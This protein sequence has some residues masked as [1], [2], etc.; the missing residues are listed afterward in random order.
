MNL[1]GK[2]KVE[3]VPFDAHEQSQK[4]A[5]RE[6]DANQNPQEFPKA[7]DHVED[8]NDPNHLEP[9]VARNPEEEK[10]YRKPES[11]DEPDH[12]QTT[13]EAKAE[14]G[15]M[16]KAQLS[17]VGASEDAGL[18]GSSTKKEMISDILASRKEAKKN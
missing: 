12:P 5:A 7:V 3:P 11:T 9:V 14:L 13:A 2:T 17:D 18:S 1:D 6:N 4:K 10:A 15:G 16:T 8:P